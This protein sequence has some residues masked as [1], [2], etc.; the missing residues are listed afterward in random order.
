MP[1]RIHYRFGPRE[2]NERVGQRQIRHRRIPAKRGES[3]HLE[4]TDGD[5]WD[6]RLELVRQFKSELVRL[7]EGFVF[8]KKFVSY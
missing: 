3:K 5:R 7:L 4:R 8:E 2:C 6:V 1:T